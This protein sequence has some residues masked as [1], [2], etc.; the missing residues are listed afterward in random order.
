MCLVGKGSI[1]VY[2]FPRCKERVDF[3]GFGGYGLW[4]IAPECVNYIRILWIWICV[5][6]MMVTMVFAC[7]LCRVWFVL[8]FGMSFP[9]FVSLLDFKMLNS[10]QIACPLWGEF[11]PW[12]FGPHQPENSPFGD[13]QIQ[14]VKQKLNRNP[15][16]NLTQAWT[17]TSCEMK[18]LWTIFAHI[19]WTFD[20]SST[21]P[22]G[23]RNHVSHSAC[24]TGWLPGK[25]VGDH[26]TD[27]SQQE[28][29]KRYL[30]MVASSNKVIVY[31]F[32]LPELT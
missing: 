12:Q 24:P 6:R 4:L 11:P 23:S 30:G 32:A 9:W 5:H 31:L 8:E 13:V 16:C 21:H 29:G 18:Q 1:D 2:L 3:E 15:V 7:S 28:I 10:I 20:V 19:G 26:A 22:S 14:N 25:A 27:S 17:T